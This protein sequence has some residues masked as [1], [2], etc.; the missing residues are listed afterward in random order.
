MSHSRRTVSQWMAAAIVLPFVATAP[1]ALALSLPVAIEGYDPVAFFREDKAVKGSPEFT[2]EWA[3]V[4]WHF[5]SAENR[6]TFKKEPADWV[7]QFQNGDL[8][9]FGLAHGRKVKG[10]P[11]QWVIVDGKLYFT[12]H[13]RARAGVQ[14]DPQGMI[15]R[16]RENAPGLGVK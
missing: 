3:G 4:T 16:A 2:A 8:C 10:D 7:P 5:S 11:K 6:D 9:P 15:S 14:A 12:A 13:E 1:P